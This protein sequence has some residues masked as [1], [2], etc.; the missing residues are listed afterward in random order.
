MRYGSIIVT[1]AKALLYQKLEEL[2]ETYTRKLPGKLQDIRDTL[3]E[4]QDITKQ[5]PESLKYLHNLVHSLVGSAGT[6]GLNELSEHMR[7][8]ET[9]IKHRLKKE[10]SIDA[11]SIEKLQA[12]LAQITLDTDTPTHTA[13][14]RQDIPDNWRLDKHSG[15]FVKNPLIYFASN[16][17]QLSADLAPQLAGFGYELQHFDNFAMLEDAVHKMSPA[18]LVVDVSDGENRIA[19]VEEVKQLQ[20]HAKT[21]CPLIFMSDQSDMR[22]RLRAVRAGGNAYFTKPIR[23]I[24]FVE[25]IDAL[26][27][28]TQHI[29]YRVLII[30]DDEQLGSHYALILRDAGMETKKITQPL[31]I[32]DSISHFK[33]DLILM[34]IYMPECT[35]IELAMVLRQNDAYLGTPIVFLSSETSESKQFHAMSQGADGFLTKPIDSQTLVQS[36]SIRAERSRLISSAMIKDSLTGLL[37]HVAFKERVSSELARA[38]RTGSEFALVLI[39]V[40]HFK[41]VNDKHG[42]LAGDRVLILLSQLLRQ[43]LRETDIIGR[44]GGE[45]FAVILPGTT[46]SAAGKVIDEIRIGFSKIIHSQNG[47]DFSVTFSAGLSYSDQHQNP[48]HLIEAADM[49]LYRAKQAGRNQVSAP[50]PASNPD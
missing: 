13:Q 39:D 11:Q 12:L 27:Q 31:Q 23:F 9:I 28:K 5:S 1:D 43:R 19:S 44:Y 48:A 7:R 45:E 3:N 24:S 50:S 33:P 6:F 40:D 49:A 34:D 14:I 47:C 38:D 17:Q 30:D 22:M 16:D 42:H 20:T 29:P 15:Q 37:N 18:I 36:V 2:R 32:M 25:R 41:D 35:G 21:S 10:H 46:L 4:A 26:T 8:M